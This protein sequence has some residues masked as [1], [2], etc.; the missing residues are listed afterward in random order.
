MNFKA[1][2]SAIKLRGAYYTDP[3]IATFLLK[4]VLHIQRKSSLESQ[5]VGD[6]VFLRSLSSLKHKWFK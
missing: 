4:W 2:E 1:N 6:G 3:A 5:A